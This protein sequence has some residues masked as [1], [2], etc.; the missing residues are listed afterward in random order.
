[1]DEQTAAVDRLLPLDFGFCSLCL[2]A[3]ERAW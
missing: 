1:L 3:P 2:A